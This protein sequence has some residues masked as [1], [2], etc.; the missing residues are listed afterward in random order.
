[1]SLHYIIDG[2]NVIKQTAEFTG[3]SLKYGRDELV[4]YLIFYRPQGSLNN[5]VTIVFDGRSDVYWPETRDGKNNIETVFSHDETAD[6]KIKK[7][8]RRAEQQ[9]NIIVVT[10]D[11]GLRNVVR[12]L[13]GK[14]VYVNG[15]MKKKRVK[16]EIV[17][18]R[19]KT[20]LSTHEQISITEEL[21]K[22]WA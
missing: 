13:G 3:R 7:I 21:K 18:L 12:Q 8:V 1:M 17:G 22:I 19:K 9:S 15:F 4:K 6:D 16:N 5:K 11:N 14:V 20:A 2:Y 10:N